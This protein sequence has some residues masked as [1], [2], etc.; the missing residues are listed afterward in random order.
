[1]NTLLASLSLY[2]S[3]LNC[4]SFFPFTHLILFKQGK[5]FWKHWMCTWSLSF[6][7]FRSSTMGLYS[8]Q[9]SQSFSSEHTKPVLEEID[10]FYW[11]NGSIRAFIQVVHLITQP[12]FECWPLSL[13]LNNLEY[14][15]LSTTGIEY[16]VC[17]QQ[18]S[19]N[20]GNCL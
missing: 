20:C 16:C 10:Q 11:S 13:K 14:L 12:Q 6:P 19:V 3:Y 2:F 9:G 18:H 5:S 15:N 7:A 8:H 17:Q 1:M 4:I